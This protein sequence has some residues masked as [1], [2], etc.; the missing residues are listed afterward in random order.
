MGNRYF[1]NIKKYILKRLLMMDSFHKSNVLQK[2]KL[3]WASSNNTNTCYK[4]QMI[5]L[6]YNL[7][8]FLK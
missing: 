5:N 2:A 8:L 7:Q 3:K 1:N 4:I 6:Q